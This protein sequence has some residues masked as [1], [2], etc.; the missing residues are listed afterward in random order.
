M[1]VLIIPSWYPSSSQDIGGSFFREQALALAKHHD[2]VG[3]IFPTLRSVK[4][5][6]VFH[7]NPGGISYVND[8]DVHTYRWNSYNWTPRI[9]I[10]IH[11]QWLHHGQNL[12]ETY[13]RRHGKPDV[14][15]AHCMLYAGALATHLRQVYNIPVVLTE[16]STGYGR[17]FYSPVELNIAKATALRCDHLLAVSND[18]A[19][20]LNRI[21]PG[22]TMNWS[23]IPNI[24]NSSFLNQP[25]NTEHNKEQQFTFINVGILRKIK[26]QELL[27]RSFAQA[28]P[29]DRNI[30]LKIAGDGPERNDLLRLINNHNLND[31]VSLLGNIPR[32]HMP[33]QLSEA[34]VFVL[35]SELETFGVVV[36]EALAMG[37]PVISTS[38]GGPNDL[39]ERSD[40][41]LVPVNDA[42]ALAEAMKR[43][44]RD[45]DNFNPLEI[46]NSCRDRFSEKA[47]CEVLTRIY[48]NLAAN[49]ARTT[50]S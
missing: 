39:I 20:K 34:D 17:E 31:R 4:A 10:G 50:Y 29:N 12:F 3:L 2:Q 21:A 35:A 48:Q 24:V 9:P 30:H 26:R 27:I 46:R 40:G 33:Q 8:N 49:A 36:I 38:C 41:V 43:I 5:L 13:V 37:L 6:A 42:A 14:I 1:H 22:K 47:V 7:K 45:I 28:F 25:V 19:Q 32:S 23:T 18:L 16:H 44:Y 15:H 11:R